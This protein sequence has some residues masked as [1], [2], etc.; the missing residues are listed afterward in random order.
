LPIFRRHLPKLL[1]PRPTPPKKSFFREHILPALFVFLIPGFS[2]WFFGFAE[3][4][5]DTSVYRI[6]EKR[7]Q[8]ES[9]IS[10]AD[11]QSTLEF[12]RKN[13]V[14]RIMASEDPKLVH[15]QDT[16][17]P[18]ANNYAVLRWMKR[19]AW[20][21]LATLLATLLI[22]G[23]SANLAARS[24]AALY[25][26][27]RI[28]WPVLRTSAAIQVIG[29]A[30][31]AVAL[32]FWI[33]AIVSE[34][35][36][37]KFMFIAAFLAFLA[38]CALFAA[39]F[40]RIDNR[41]TIEGESVSEA[42]A[43]NLWQRVREMA[44]KLNTAPPAQII[45]GID[46]N[47]FVTEHPVTV[48][49]ATYKGRTLFLSLPLLKVMD[50]SEADAVLGHEL[51]H[52]SGDDTFW[53]RK[54]SPLKS[55]FALYLQ[56][57]G[58]GVAIAV[59]GFMH[60]F[61]KIYMVA[62]GRLSRAREFRADRVGSELVSADAMKRALIKVTTYGEYRVETERS[63]LKEK[64]V[65]EGLDLA[66]RLEQGYPA[67]VAIFVHSDKANVET[68][69]HPFDSHP[70]LA[71][72]VAQIGFEIRAALADPEIKKTATES[73]YQTISTAPELEARLWKRQQ[74]A[75]Q[76]YHRQDLAYRIMP[77][78]DEEAAIVEAQFPRVVFRNMR[79]ATATLDYDRIQL[80][81]W[82]APVFLK[83][84][85]ELRLEGTFGGNQLS[86]W[87]QPDGAP[88][89]LRAKLMAESYRSAEGDLLTVLKKY[90]ARHQ[91]ATAR[92]AVEE[93]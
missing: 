36:Y 25:T 31:L 55:R 60:L 24:Q 16:F 50:V 38:V 37:V 47:F 40:T 78:E 73:W 54:I 41:F 65:D 11:K 21:C 23:V 43:P 19:I 84:I 6:I 26:A 22:V 27:L 79:Q 89:P 70:T 20:I 87:H 82:K 13:P 28:G 63:I 75:L 33:T 61:W 12:Y 83:D 90:Y 7:V 29:Q 81:E 14:S 15:A 76:S 46:S 88:K 86:I 2:A 48:G 49:P 85:V 52:F 67:F 69:P 72:R 3:H 62:L 39:I 5:F 56:K 53:S 10:E 8:A 34:V 59:A 74:D 71:M 1:K 30:I 18:M 80:A 66:Q 4:S 35:Y 51:A 77:K 44:A 42:D 58:A 92:S 93:A 9:G 32:S 68:V 64:R 91:V 45:A 57:L 17:E